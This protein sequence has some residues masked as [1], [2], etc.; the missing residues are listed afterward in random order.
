MRIEIIPIICDLYLSLHVIN[1]DSK[2]DN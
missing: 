1:S 2:M